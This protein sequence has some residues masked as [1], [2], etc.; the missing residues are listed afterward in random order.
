MDEDIARDLF[1]ASEKYALPELMRICED[2]LINHITVEN[3]VDTINLAEKFEANNLRNA[4]LKF[5]AD[6]NFKKVFD[7]EGSMRLKNTT[8][9]EIFSMKP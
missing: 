6:G 8:L 1:E 2:F 4:A 9:L 5:L 3:V 7:K